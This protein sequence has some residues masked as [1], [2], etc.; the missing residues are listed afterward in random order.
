MQ[1]MESVGQYVQEAV[2]LM[3]SG[4]YERAVPPTTAAIDLTVRKINGKDTFS[5]LDC[6]R[7]IKD[8]WPLISFMG[9]PHALPLAMSVPFA[10][11][12]IMPSF[13]SLHGATEM[14]SLLVTE[15]LKQRLMP[16]EFSFNWTGKFEVKN[17]RL[18]L[19]SG[20][21]CGL[22]GSVIFHPSNTGEEIGEMYWISISDFK[23][24]VSELFGRKD[25]VD[26][27]MKFYLE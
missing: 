20:L 19:P 17:S 22:L 9:M 11:K 23:M 27:I 2:D 5:E 10:F 18:L 16:T 6:G 13:N 7:F 3:N 21:V 14:V 24:F 26:R 4:S 25:L 1:R 8:N 12:Q 15:T